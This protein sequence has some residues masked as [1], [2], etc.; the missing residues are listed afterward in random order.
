MPAST[1][2]T[3]RR[4]RSRGAI[5]P[6]LGL[7]DADASD[8]ARHPL[9]RARRRGERRACCSQLD[10][11]VQ[12][13][14]GHRGRRPPAEDRDGQ[15]RL[16]RLVR[17]PPRR[18]VRARRRVGLRQD[19][20][21]LARRGA[22]PGRRRARSGST[23]EDMATLR[24]RALRRARRDLQLMF[25]DPYASLDPRM[26]VGPI[27]QRAARRPAASARAPTG[28]SAS[29]ELLA[30]VGL[31]PK[32]GRALSARVLGRPAAA[33]RPRARARAQP[34]ADRRRRARLRARRLDP[35]ADPQPD[36]RACSDAHELTYIVI[37]HDL[38]VVRYLADTIG[39]M[40]LGKLVEIGPAD[41]DLR[42]A[43][44]PVHARADR[45]DRRFPIPVLEKQR[46]TV[47]GARRAAV[48][49]RPAVGLPLPHA[50]PAR[51]GRSAPRIEPPL[52][53]FGGGHRAACH[54]P[55]QT[56]DE[57]T[58]RSPPSGA[59]AGPRRRRAGR[60]RRS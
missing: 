52:R 40:Y 15:G 58:E 53:S 43:G 3:P 59:A 9:G 35:G 54:F 31:S 12:G 13:V 49:D 57:S 2:S 48:G 37:S 19:D 7:V 27:D 50:L 1:R 6:E 45:R 51:A 16:G 11:L 14:P 28:G 25:Q 39:V 4:Q 34:E 30:E 55:L 32:C 10:H 44:A 46:E 36:A 20:D 56:P 22:A 26:R 23:G 33:H 21:R 38:A 47:A 18:D 8:A 29:R 17:R 41:D 42:A 5:A 60:R 24:G